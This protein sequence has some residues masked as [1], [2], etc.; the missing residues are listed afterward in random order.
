MGLYRYT[1]TCSIETNE[2]YLPPGIVV[3]MVA[4]GPNMPGTGNKI[5]NL[6][7]AKYGVAIKASD[8]ICWFKAEEIS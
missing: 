7:E 4:Y 6:V 3:E 5:K 2:G 8:P 1:S